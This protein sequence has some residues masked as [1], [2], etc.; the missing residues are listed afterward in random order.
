MGELS[1]EAKKAVDQTNLQMHSERDRRNG[2]EIT[3]YIE[4]HPGVGFRLFRSQ[5]ADKILKMEERRELGG[6]APEIRNMAHDYITATD[7]LV[8]RTGATVQDAIDYGLTPAVSTLEAALNAVKDRVIGGPTAEREKRDASNT[9]M[10][11]MVAA[12]H[13]QYQQNIDKATVLLESMQT[14][15]A[16]VH[17]K[18]RAQT[19]GH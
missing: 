1:E 15:P 17:S 19:M 10:N 13:A 14:A 9:K 12:A 5:L 6:V 3:T 4:Q 18:E 2:A 8:N 7:S 11:E 16:R